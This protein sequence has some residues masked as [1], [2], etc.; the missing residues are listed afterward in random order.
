MH[1]IEHMRSATGLT[2]SLISY[3]TNES[4][5]R[6]PG[7]SACME[8]I[9]EKVCVLFHTERSLIDHPPGHTGLCR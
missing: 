5:N 6:H 8:A 3:F 2:S 9:A 1:D 7:L 4:L